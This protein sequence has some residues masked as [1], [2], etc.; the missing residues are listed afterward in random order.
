MA[1]VMRIVGYGLFLLLLA[2]L[3]AQ[4]AIWIT[5]GTAPLAD[6]SRQKGMFVEHPYLV[7]VPRP[8]T[9][10]RKKDI[11]ISTD[12]LGFRGRE[13]AWAGHDSVL[14]VLALG[15]STTF[16]AM[17][18][19]EETWPVRLDA[20][21]DS[22]LATRV[23]T[24]RSAEVINGGVPGYTSAENLIQLA[25][26][27]VHLHPDVVVLFQ[28]YND[29]R[30]AHSPGL[31]TDYSNFHAVSQRGSLEL[32]R[33]RW[34]MRSGL[35]RFWREALTR[36]FGRERSGIVLAQRRSGMDSKALDIYRANLRTFAGMCRSHGISCLFVP[37]VISRAH[38]M[39]E[40]WLLYL[41]PAAVEP[42]LAHYN[43]AMQEVAAATATPFASVV[44]ETHWNSAD[45]TDHAHFSSTGNWKFAAMI[46]PHVLNLAGARDRG[47][48]ASFSP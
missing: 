20:A 32:D 10:V 47:A 31:R 40:W 16:G 12:S 15:G 26:V 37:Q 18:S 38:K 42:M 4:A 7:G 2:E 14:R 27:G 39:N 43:E 41:E 3:T 28:S 25:L 45:F 23:A 19:D 30:N 33:L 8:G 35:V 29:M 34:G 44:T 24:F 6:G 48:T 21:L 46:A 1:R 5:T 36:V 17:V 22:M 11:T 13:I 9:T